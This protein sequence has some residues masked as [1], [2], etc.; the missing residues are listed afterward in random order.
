MKRINLR[1]VHCIHVQN[2]KPHYCMFRQSSVFSPEML[3]C[4]GILG[5]DC[6][7][8]MPDTVGKLVTAYTYE[9]TLFRQQ[10]GNSHFRHNGKF[11]SEN[12]AHVHT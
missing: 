2:N 10:R 7:V 11:F 8:S 4:A 6:P 3:N 1:T 9:R 5:G 12:D